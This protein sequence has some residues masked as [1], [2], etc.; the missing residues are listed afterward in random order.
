MRM[1]TFIIFSV[2]VMPVAI[3]NGILNSPSWLSLVT[4]GLAGA[5][6]FL[7]RNPKD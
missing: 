5:L 1:K 7:I 3:I 4:G 6:A 2:C